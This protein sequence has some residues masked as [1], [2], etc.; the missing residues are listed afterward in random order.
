M[1]NIKLINN[2]TIELDMYYKYIINKFVDE[3]T[4]NTL[5][6]Y[7]SDNKFELLKNMSSNTN[8]MI[9]AIINNNIFELNKL[10]IE[11]KENIN[12]KDDDGESL[13]NYAFHFNKYE[14]CKLLLK[15]KIDP[16]S[17]DKWGQ[18]CLHK[19]N[20]NTNSKIIRFIYK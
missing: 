3:I 12:Y 18:I 19:T 2:D 10:L 11:N 6:K 20:S 5:L 14:I 7:N 17:T 4:D 15:Y 16:N 9:H 13:L 1:A 8:P